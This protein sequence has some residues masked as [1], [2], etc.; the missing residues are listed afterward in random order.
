M[1]LD[2]GGEARQHRDRR[3][4]HQLTEPRDR[5]PE[6]LAAHLEDRDLLDHLGVEV[7]LMGTPQALAP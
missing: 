5:Y 3:A 1:P 6:L 2:P 7:P 4:S